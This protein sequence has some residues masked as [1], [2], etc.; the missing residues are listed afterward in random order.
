MKVMK[1]EKDEKDNHN[2]CVLEIG[3]GT[4]SEVGK[5][6]FGSVVGA[7]TEITKNVCHF[8]SHSGVMTAVDKTVC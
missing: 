1:V 8:L 3:K 2:S 5:T 6:E 4:Q 7:R